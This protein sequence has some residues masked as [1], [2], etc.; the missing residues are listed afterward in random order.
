MVSTLLLLKATFFSARL[1]IKLHHI[2]L[3]KPFTPISLSFSKFNLSLFI[4]TQMW[5]IKCKNLAFRDHHRN[6]IHGG[7]RWGGGHLPVPS[8]SR[9][10]LP[11]IMLLKAMV[12]WPI[13]SWP[14]GS[15]SHTRKRTRASSGMWTVNT[16]VSSHIGLNPVGPSQERS[17]RGGGGGWR[18]GGWGRREQEEDRGRS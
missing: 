8:T 18:G 17:R 16:R 11:G 13:K 12:R 15:W 14:M 3:N 6:T 9:C 5:G 10:F 4:A 1:L 2:N 7:G